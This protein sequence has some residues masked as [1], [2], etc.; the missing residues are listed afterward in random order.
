MKKIVLVLMTVLMMGGVAMAQQPG[1]RDRK[2]PDAKE[3]AERMTERMAKELSL[4]DAQKQQVLEANMALAEKTDGMPMPPRRPGKKDSK[5]CASCDS[6]CQQ[7][8]EAPAPG[9][10]KEGMKKGNRPELTDEQKAE[11]QQKRAAAKEARAVYDAR[12]KEIL[13][14][15]QYQTFT[16]KMKAPK[17]GKMEKRR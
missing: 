14:P 9:E 2:A 12:M 6:C 15:E 10:R 16:E 4:T 7:K 3:R 11:M 5:C 8:G 17:P 1:G 13:T